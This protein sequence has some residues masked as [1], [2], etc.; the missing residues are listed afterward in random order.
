MKRLAL[1]LSILAGCLCFAQQPNNLAQ[2]GGTN[3]NL[4]ATLF[5]AVV[6]TGTATSSAIGIPQWGGYGTL[7]ISGASITGSPTGCTIALAYQM[8]TGGSQTTAQATISFT[9]GNSTQVFPVSPTQVSGDQIVATYACSGTYPTAGTI[10]TTF[11][12][13][14]A[15]QVGQYNSALPT[16]VSGNFGVP[17][18]DVNGRLIEVGAGVA[19]T[20]AGGVASVQGVT[21]MTPLAVSATTAANSNSNPLFASVTDGTTKATV[22]SATAA[23]KTDMSSVAGTATVTAASGVQKVGITGNANASLDAAIGTIPTNNLAA[24]LVPTTAAGGALSSSGKSAVTTSVNVKASAGNVYGLSVVSGATSGCW[25][26]LINSA[27][28]GTL[29]TA[30]II[31]IALPNAGV[32]NI[33]PG[34]LALGNFSSGIAVGVASAIGG[35]TVCATASSITVIFQ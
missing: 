27:T 16:L 7:Q 4:Y 17:E 29:G 35:G 2:I 19:G 28:A 5:N 33:P 6:A 18:L 9:P 20:P 8:S 12:P 11:A 13:S 1:V 25:L 26:E 3:V 24:I 22:I 14:P 30:V 32:V 23:L 21:S 34:T 31:N 10:S 15:V